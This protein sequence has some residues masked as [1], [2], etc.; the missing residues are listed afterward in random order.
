MK[1]RGHALV[2]H[3]QT[4]AWVF[5][6]SSGGAASRDMVLARMRNHITNVMRHFQGRSTPGTSSTRR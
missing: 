3:R 5:T 1:V 6:N 2:W 4:P